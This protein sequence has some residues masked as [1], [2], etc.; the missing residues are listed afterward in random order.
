MAYLIAFLLILIPCSVIAAPVAAI[1]VSAAVSGAVAASWTVF[2]ASLVLGA[3]SYALTPRIKAKDQ[4][5]FVSNN[6]ISIRQSDLTRQIVYGQTRITR[7]YAQIEKQEV[8]NKLHIALILCEGTLRDIGEIW[9]ED[10]PIPPD[11]IDADGNVIAGRYAGNL[12][13]RKHLGDPG[14]VADPLMV[15]NLPNWSSQHRLR[16]IAY[17]YI[18][19]TKNQDI[20]PNGVPNITAIV[21]GPTL[22]DPRTESSLWTTNI[23]LFAA[24]FIR[25]STYGFGA[26]DDDVDFA[27][28]SAQAN[29]CDEIVDVDGEEIVVSDVDATTNIITI[30]GSLLAY[31]YG[32]RVEVSSTGTLPSGLSS[33]TAYYVI[34]YQIKENAR[35]KLATSLANA[36]AKVA[37]DLS[38]EGSGDITIFKTGEPRY[39]GGGIV[40]TED[41]LSP[42]LNNIVSCMAGRAINVAGFWTLL[43]GAW[44]TPAVEYTIDD[45][46]GTDIRVQSNLS[47]SDSYNVVKGLFY[48]QL[49]NY[50]PSDYPSVYYGEFIEADNGI[51]SPRELNLLFIGR[52][53]TCQRIAK[54]EEFRGRQGIV[55]EASFSMKGIRVQTGDNIY[56]TLD[57]YGWEDKAFEVTEF[58]FIAQ[59]GQLI[60]RM[61]LRETAEAIFDWSDGEAITYDPAP[62]SNFPDYFNVQI[63]SGVSYS[64]RAI[65]TAAGDTLYSM[66]LSWLLHPDAF[67]REFGDF[68]LQFKLSSETEWR[69]S[70]FVDG[71]LTE[72]DVVNSSVNTLYDLRIRAR[73]NLGVRSGWVTILEAIVGSSGG[74]TVDGDFGLVTASPTIFIDYG[75]VADPTDSSSMDYG[76][77]V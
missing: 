54:I 2:A 76:F 48:S 71:S 64:S 34:P 33:S 15:A 46:R 61:T 20:Y 18:I 16:G 22:Y 19:M 6:T 25:S 5:S 55:V 45:L 28:I 38:S 60:T 56:L 12:V 66:T 24:D 8:N 62:N 40:D 68:E 70:F 42:T 27:N 13:I 43:A 32:D 57:R 69:P 26:F 58:N 52:P 17:L 67:V 50:Q 10:Y 11:H 72:T 41:D 63:P 51:E 65:D 23:A 37:I 39:H 30:E 9:L 1:V 44:R 47:M 21:E 53:T 77:V 75:S 29:I 3:I 74:V 36:L 31:E 73:N 59:D 35:L 7:G 4:G 14:Q 49:N